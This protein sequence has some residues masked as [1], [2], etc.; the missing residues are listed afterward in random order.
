MDDIRNTNIY[1]AF[2]NEMLFMDDFSDFVNNENCK[3]QIPSGSQL[4][5]MLEKSRERA[6]QRGIK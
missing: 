5:K 4:A 2:K 1:R 6:L 3:P